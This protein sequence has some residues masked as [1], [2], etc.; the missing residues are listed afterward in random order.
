L[1][2]ARDA[3]YALVFTT[4]AFWQWGGA[5]AA[6]LLALIATEIAITL[7][8]FAVE[9]AVRA[10]LGGVF[11]GERITHTLMAIVYSAALAHLVPVF[12]GDLAAPTGFTP[13]PAPQPL[14]TLL[15]LLAAGVL[16]SGV[17]DAV[18]AFLGPRAG[19]PW[20]RWP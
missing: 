8:D 10:K 5:L 17:R 16:A 9:D 13:R 4:L 20:P 3:V 1:H 11:K 12:L 6:V 18:A 14:A 15:L 19:W 7:V 2:A